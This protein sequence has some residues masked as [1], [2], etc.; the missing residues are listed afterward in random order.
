[1]NTVTSTRARFFALQKLTE[2]FES[3]VDNWARSKAEHA[4][5]ISKENNSTLTSGEEQI[6]TLC[7]KY[8]DI[9]GNITHLENTMRSE[10][11]KE[12]AMRREIK[13]LKEIEKKQTKEIPNLVSSLSSL[14]IGY[15]TTEQSIQSEQS[16]RLHREKD[17]NDKV[18]LIQKYLGLCFEPMQG[19][20]LLRVVF[21]NIDPISPSK[22]YTFCVKISS[23]L[24]S[25]EQFTP[26]ISIPREYL[27]ELNRFGD[28]GKF[29]AQVRFLFIQ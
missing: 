13:N 26:N 21:T 4:E 18:S 25:V 28:F 23:S 11:E 27:E 12:D 6:Q 22:R 7:R 1:M 14:S 20:H 15:Q 17:M 9:L 19:E 3:R 24:Y 16:S 2:Q 8:Q 5:K 29:L 10:G